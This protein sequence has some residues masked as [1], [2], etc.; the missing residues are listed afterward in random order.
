MEV[1]H[2]REQTFH[3]EA[4]SDGTRRHVEKF[5]AVAR[6]SFVFYKASL[7]SRC[8]GKDILEYG[9]G[10]DGYSLTFG[11][12]AASLTGVDLSPVAVGIAKQKVDTNGKR[13]A[14]FCVMNAEELAFEDSSFDVICGVAI[15]HHLDLAKA[16]AEVSR[17]LR[18]DGVAIFL[19]PLGHNPLINGYRRLTPKLRTPDEHP[20]LMRDLSLAGTYFSGVETRFF[21]LHPLLALPLRDWPGFSHLLDAL[22]VLDRVAFRAV[23][24]TKRYAWQVVMV[25]TGPKRPN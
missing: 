17:V 7:Q 11:I 8:A 21:T 5:Y 3:D 12:A 19:E 6:D 1:R 13:R 16:Y 9:C 10:A 18:P 22:A 23:P 20:L 4:F 14:R 25:L 15:L 24:L 2:Y